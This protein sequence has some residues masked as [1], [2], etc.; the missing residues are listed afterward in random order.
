MSTYKIIDLVGKDHIKVIST[1][2]KLRGIDGGTL[3]VD[4]GQETTDE[5]LRGYIRVVIDYNE[6]RLVKVE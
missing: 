5:K 3:K 4:T 2:A 6:I 1:P